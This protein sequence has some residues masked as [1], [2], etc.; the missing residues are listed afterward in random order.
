MNAKETLNWL[1]EC[2]AQEALYERAITDENNCDPLSCWVPSRI[3]GHVETH[4]KGGVRYLLNNVAAAFRKQAQDLGITVICQSV[5]ADLEK[6]T[7][8]RN[9]LLAARILLLM[10]GAADDDTISKHI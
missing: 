8:R 6:V 10:K 3:H 2:G 9:D 7:V 1:A 4:L 5:S